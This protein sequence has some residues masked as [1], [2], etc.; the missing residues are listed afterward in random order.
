M[1][2]GNTSATV[3]RTIAEFNGG[4]R[5][6]LR[7]AL[8]HDFFSHA[9]A[10]GEPGAA[11]VIGPIILDLVGG[12]PDLAIVLDALESDGDGAHG[13]ATLRG[14]NTGELW[15]VPA[16]GRAIA[17]TVAFSVRPVDGG[18]ALNLDDLT[19]P[20]IIEMLRQ[21]ELV[22]AADQMHLPPKHAA[23]MPPEFLLRLAFNGQVADKACSHLGQVV[24][25]RRDATA[26]SECGPDDVWPALR[27]CLTCGHAGC[28]D[29]SVNKHAR[30]HFEETGHPLMRSLRAGEAW[31]WCYADGVFLGGATLAA[32]AASSGA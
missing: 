23:S 4:D 2:P 13:R 20:S 17:W 31:G 8:G 5:A 25:S 21:L 30:A 15:G 14:T 24:V 7:A 16:T 26:C 10:D 19:L 9:P 18:L 12:F 11:E 27:L 29:T 3:R 22:N 32:A 1:R 6:A 28:C